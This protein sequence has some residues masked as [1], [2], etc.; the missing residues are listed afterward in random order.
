MMGF[1]R[2]PRRILIVIHDLVVTT[3]AMLATLY[4]RFADGQNGGLGVRYSWLVAILPCFVDKS[5]FNQLRQTYA[6]KV[7]FCEAIEV[8]DCFPIPLQRSV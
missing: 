4:V 1:L 8:S 6:S 3:L 7:E 2:N 5:S